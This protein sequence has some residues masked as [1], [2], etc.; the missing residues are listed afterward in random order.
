MTFQRSRLR[1]RL[2][3]ALLLVGVAL[4]VGCTTVPL[5]DLP[6]GDGS[7][8]AWRDAENAWDRVLSEH[9]TPDGRVDFAAIAADRDDLD[10]FVAAVAEASPWSHPAR[11]P[12]RADTLAYAINS[13]NALAIYNT[14]V[15]ENRPEQ[16]VRFFIRN[17]VTVGGERVSLYDYENDWLRPLDEPRLHFA[18]NCLARSC[19]R[20]PA[21]AFRATELDAT[22]DALTREFLNDPRHVEVDDASRT[23]RLSAILDWYEEDFRVVAPSLLEYVNRYRESPIPADYRVEF[24]EYDWTRNDAS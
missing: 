9:V 19:P 2:T 15:T 13:Y 21:R 20:L 16:L 8:E 17:R 11:F 18:L 6:A 4:T 12:D 10:R 24:L 5:P 22:L 23:I 14:V 7:P 1:R 3:N